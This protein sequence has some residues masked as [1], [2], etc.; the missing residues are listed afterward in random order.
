MII[1]DKNPVAAIKLISVASVCEHFMKILNLLITTEAN[2]FKR[3]PILWNIT[4]PNG[5]PTIAY[6]IQKALPAN[7]FG[8]E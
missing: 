6:N 4:S 1:D 8:V 5:I 2:L 7:V 3:S